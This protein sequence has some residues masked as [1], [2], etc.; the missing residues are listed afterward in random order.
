MTLD[1]L[2]C[3]CAIVETGSFRRAAER[4]HR[5]QPAVSQ[6]VKSLE[7]ELKCVL[8]ERSTSRLTPAGERF[9]KRARH[10]LNE[11]DSL[12]NEIRDFDETQQ[13]PLR[14]GTSDTTALYFL[15][16]VVRTFAM[17]LPQTR[18]EI[19]NRPSE[20][21]AGQVAKGQLDVGIVTLPVE[22]DGL[23]AQRLFE[24][25]LVLVTPA[26]HRLSRRK[27]LALS[28]LRDEPMLLLDASTRT[29]RLLKA[30]FD[31]EGFEPQVVL[32]SGSF[33][34]IK[35]YVAQ[36]VGVAFL[37]QMT[38]TKSDRGLAV[39]HVR[40]VPSVEIGAITRRGAYQSKAEQVFLE[41]VSERGNTD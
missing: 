28:W 31:E 37:P 32:D 40:G 5:S 21:I 1:G 19:V 11:T 33:E 2:R 36:G 29:G 38:I 13:R 25:R 35:R 10:I 7:R 14:L 15:P 20:A 3:L 6:Q 17:R 26:G 9:Y 39:L 18:L 41:I 34:V 16:D 23:E 24:Q 30:Y 4:V 22:R 12:A 27:R 8:I